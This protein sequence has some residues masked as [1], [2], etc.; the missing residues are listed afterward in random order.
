MFR[1]LNLTLHVMPPPRLPARMPK[2]VHGS[3]LVLKGNFRPAFHIMTLRYIFKSS[4]HCFA[5]PA[6][7]L[8]NR[9]S[10]VERNV[11]SRT[12]FSPQS[13]LHISI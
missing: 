12:R 7:R 2:T 9:G 6:Q 11:L 13:H 5:N 1:Q 3:I 8:A 10:V 4:K